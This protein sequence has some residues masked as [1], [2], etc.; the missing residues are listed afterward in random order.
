[1]NPACNYADYID[2]GVVKKFEMLTG[3]KTQIAT[4][5]SARAQHE[6]VGQAVP[7]SSAIAPRISLAARSRST[8]PR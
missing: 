4:Y 5:N 6:H 7:S 1:L 2:P 8:R 3:T